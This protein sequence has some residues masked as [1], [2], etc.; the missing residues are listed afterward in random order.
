[1]R[2]WFLIGALAVLLLVWWLM[3][4]KLME[5]PKDERPLGVRLNNPGNVKDLPGG[6][7]WIGQIGKD[8]NG[9]AHFDTVENGARAMSIDT[10]GD[11]FQD[12]Q[13]TLVKLL[14]TYAPVDD[15][16]ANNNPTAYARFVGKKVGLATT[17]LIPASKFKAI[18]YAMVEFEQRAGTPIS[19]WF[20]LAEL[21][22]GFRAGLVKKGFTPSKMGF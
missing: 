22:R 13:N 21:D 2:K 17:S 19:K 12:G 10:S 1:M 18:L 14:S 3:S 4:D 5:T 9:H 7:N 15:A 6:D 8:K 11:I 16:A 20:D